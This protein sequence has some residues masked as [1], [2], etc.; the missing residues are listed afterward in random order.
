MEENRVG[1]LLW[2]RVVLNGAERG[3]LLVAESSWNVRRAALPAP[4]RPYPK[5]PGRHTTYWR[6]VN[7]LCIV[8]SGHVASFFCRPH[9]LTRTLTPSHG[10]LRTKSQT[11]KVESTALAQRVLRHLQSHRKCDR[12]CGAYRASIRRVRMRPLHRLCGVR[13][14]CVTVV[15]PQRLVAFGGNT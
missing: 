4:T 15:P 13:E 8:F 2:L 7:G 12:L 10:P 9:V 5:N 11:R 1:R 14:A 6:V 3:G